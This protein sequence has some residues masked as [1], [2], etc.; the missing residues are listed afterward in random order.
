MYGI[1]TFV[2][3]VAS[4]A[5]DVG[6]RIDIAMSHIGVSFVSSFGSVLPVIVVSEPVVTCYFTFTSGTT[7]IPGTILYFEI[8]S[9]NVIFT[10]TLCTI[11]T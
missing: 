9:S 8:S 10:G 6:K 3:E 5:K 7:D 11:F 2:A 4:I 1:A